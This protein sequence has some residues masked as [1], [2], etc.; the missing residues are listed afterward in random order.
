MHDS[1]FET[2]PTVLV[3]SALLMSFWHPTKGRLSGAWHWTGVAISLSQ[4]LGLHLGGERVPTRQR[5]LLRR[6][7][8]CCL[9]RDHWLSFCLKLPMRM[10]LRDC[11]VD[12]ASINDLWNEIRHIS[13]ETKAQSIEIDCYQLLSCWLILLKITTAMASTFARYSRVG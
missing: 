11:E 2:D 6:I 1:G 7:W 9:L 3:Q 8:W 4:D 12:M 10:T 13:V 5:P